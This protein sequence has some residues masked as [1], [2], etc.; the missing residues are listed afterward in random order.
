MLLRVREIEVED[1][2]EGQ[3]RRSE[4]R[5]KVIPPG[6]KFIG[7]YGGQMRVQVS[8]SGA[9]GHNSDMPAVV[10]DARYTAN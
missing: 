1:F 9:G 5:R 4:D 3:C 8:P 2:C 7:S 6:M 10:R